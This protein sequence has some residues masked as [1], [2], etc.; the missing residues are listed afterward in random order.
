MPAMK[1]QGEYYETFFSFLLHWS[2]NIFLYSLSLFRPRPS[3]NSGQQGSEQ[4]SNEQDDEEKYSFYYPEKWVTYSCVKSS[5]KTGGFWKKKYVK[6]PP[7]KIYIWSSSD[8]F[9]SFDHSAKLLETLRR[10]LPAGNAS[11]KPQKVIIVGAGM[12]G[13]TAAKLLKDAGHE[14]TILEASSRVGGRAQ[15]FR[16][17]KYCST[18]SCMLYL[19]YLFHLCHL[20]ATITPITAVPYIILLKN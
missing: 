9:A 2:A 8:C 11:W 15:T 5:S 1:M 12:A 20:M 17:G 6:T 14:V 3:R 13:L 10:G 7:K 16:W 4:Q 19:F 18:Y